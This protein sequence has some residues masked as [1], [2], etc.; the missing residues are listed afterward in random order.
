[1]AWAADNG[2]S[3][4]TINS[5]LSTMRV[6]INYAVEREELDR[7]PFRNV[8]KA[9]DSPKEK[10][11]LTFAERKKL[12]NAKP[13]D[14]RSR[15]AVLLG[16]LCGMRRGEV[17]GLKWGDFDNGLISLTHNF[18]NMD[19]LKKPKRGK[20][21]TVP[22]PNIVEKALEEVRKISIHPTMDNYVFESFDR[23]GKPMGESFF[24][25][26]IKRE[27]KGIGITIDEQKKR[28]LSFHSLRHSFI[29][30][31]RL[32]GISDMEIQAIARYSTRKMMEHYSHADKVIDF[33]ITKEKIENAIIAKAN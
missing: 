20:V 6:A 24:R 32:D 28:N 14:P 10:G 30:L 5:V 13:T 31:G 25:N 27:L 7:S 22:Y 33:N 21:R 29:T 23:P 19:G 17:R 9:S 15:L 4:R 12:I 3:G 16:L 26:A 1:M 8:K 2:L 18:V 11:V